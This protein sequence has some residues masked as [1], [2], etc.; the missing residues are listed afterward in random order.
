MR[1]GWGSSRHPPQTRRPHPG[2]ED[3]VWWIKAAIGTKKSRGTPNDLFFFLG[4]PRRKTGS[5]SRRED[6][7]RRSGAWKC[8]K[9]AAPSPSP[10]PYLPRAGERGGLPGQPSKLGDSGWG[11]GETTVLPVTRALAP[12]V[13]TCRSASHCRK[14]PAQS[15]PGRRRALS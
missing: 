11:E 7:P 15:S 2:W 12:E 10:P 1:R 5:E 4:S 9:I 13:W 3:S 6:V 14:S 8:L